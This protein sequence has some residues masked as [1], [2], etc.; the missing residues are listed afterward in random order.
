MAEA[1]GSPRIV[2]E[3]F[4]VAKVLAAHP[5]MLRVK[6]GVGVFLA[7]YMRRFR[8]KRVGQNLILHSHLPPLTSAAYARFVAQH[9]LAR[10]P[11][12]SHAQVGLTNECPQDCEYCYNKQRAGAPMDTDTILRV[13][14]DLKRMGVVWLGFTGGEPLLNRDIVK[15]TAHAAGDCAVKLFTTGCGLTPELAHDLTAAGMFSV[16]VSLD[17]WQAARHDAAR[18]YAGAFTTALDAIAMFKQ[19]PGLHVSVSAVVS[20]EMIQSGDVARLLTFLQSLEVDE[21]WLSEVKPSIEALWR[22]EL[23]ITDEER[24]GLVAMQDAYNRRGGMTV[25]YLG[26]FE[27]AETFGCNAGGK[28]VYVDAFGDVSPCVFVPMVFGNVRERSLAELVGDM[29]GLFPGE[30]RCF[31]NKNFRPLGEAGGELPL[32]GERSRALLGGVTFGPPSAFGKK[33]FGD[34]HGVHR[35]R[36]ENG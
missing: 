12:P 9:L 1:H 27:G 10:V 15:I 26:H 30:A 34:Q 17:H 3:R 8:V 22:D 13:I 18:R 2:T 14:D 21:A 5:Q 24:L 35:D 25:N 23:V 16:A 19:V 32:D 36:S 29:C 31:I 28:M 4:A 33:L 7:R 6:P 11:G 20:R